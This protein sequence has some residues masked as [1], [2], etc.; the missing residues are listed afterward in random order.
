M[1]RA[2]SLLS[3]SRADRR[4]RQPTCP[5]EDTIKS[6]ENKEVKIRPGK[7]IVNSTDLAR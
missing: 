2:G 5:E 7:V 4:P 1:R 6:L 3:L